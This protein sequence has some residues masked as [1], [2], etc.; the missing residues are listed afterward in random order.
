MTNNTMGKDMCGIVGI[1]AER[2]VADL[3]IDGLRRLEYRGYDSA[4]IATLVKGEIQTRRAVGKLQS[5]A[6]KLQKEPLRGTVGI[7]TRA[8]RR[9]AARAK[10]MRILIFR[11]RSPSSTTASSKTTANCARSWK[12]R[13]TS[14]NPKRT[15]KPSST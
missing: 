7:V 10:T 11:T 5:L 2:P 4:G 1:L 9:M 6:D 13:N 14:S 8:G 3:L 12:P 15:P